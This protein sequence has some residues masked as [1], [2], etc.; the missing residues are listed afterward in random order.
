L[1]KTVLA[2]GLLACFAGWVAIIFDALGPTGTLA[3]CDSNDTCSSQATSLWGAGITGSEVAFLAAAAILWLGVAIG[4][5][6][7]LVRQSAAGATTLAGC[8]AVLLGLTLL[9]AA[10]IGLTFLPADVIGLVCLGIAIRSKKAP[11]GL[12]HD[13]VAQPRPPV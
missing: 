6:L 4:A 10:S 12:D 9:S 7:I 5:F 2:C 8:L 11:S 1:R 3:G 13:H